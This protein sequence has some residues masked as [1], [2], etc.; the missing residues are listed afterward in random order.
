VAATTD[1]GIEL[2]W[3]AGREPDVAG[4]RVYR[5]SLAEPQ[6]RLLTQQLHTRPY[7]VDAQTSKG[8]TYYYYVVAVDNSP[9]ANQSLPSEPVEITR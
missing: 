5:R 4:Y 7:Y 6:F 8:V 1:K 3:D 9:R 2:R